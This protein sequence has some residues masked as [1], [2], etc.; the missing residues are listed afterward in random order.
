MWCS[1]RAVS[2]ANNQALR[3]FAGTVLVSA[4]E[5]DSVLAADPHAAILP[6]DGDGVIDLD[7]LRARL[8][9]VEGPAIVSVMLANNE[10]G[11][12]Q[13][14]A[15]VSAIARE[16]GALLHCDAV[17]AA[18]KIAV[19]M[20]DLQAD[21]LTV[22]AHKLGGPQGVG[23]LVVRDGL[24]PEPLVRGG[25]QE[26]RRRAGTENVPGIA[27]FGVAAR[28]AHENLGSA[29]AVSRLRDDLESRAREHAPDAVVYGEAVARLANTSCIGLPGVT[30]E[31]QV[32]TLDLA[33]VAVSA[34]SACSSGKVSPSHVL[35]AM[36]A[37]E[38]AAKSAIRVSLGRDTGAKDID[39]FVEVW[40]DMAR[41][42]STDM[43]NRR[44][45]A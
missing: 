32:M 9:D 36:G 42:R 40:S 24:D 35:R 28:H 45:V 41:R 34:G 1:R 31:I 5:H 4:V 19:D 7:A 30:G 43:Q 16:F 44:S 33:G 18:G 12:I 8:A 37:D 11:V 10:T 6:V 23:A 22:S 17:Q 3:G 38:D 21:L 20:E 27:G 25:G 14:V 13:P 26:R 29:A 2:E 15:E 39:R